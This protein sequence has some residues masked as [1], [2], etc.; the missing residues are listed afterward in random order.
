MKPRN[1]T[2]PQIIL[3]TSILGILTGFL[4]GLIYRDERPGLN[5]LKVKME[6]MDA[7]NAVVE[8]REIAW[9][10]CGRCHNQD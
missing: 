3:V 10:F 1:L 8:Q 5:Q 7:I 4:G 6:M 9:V 2:I